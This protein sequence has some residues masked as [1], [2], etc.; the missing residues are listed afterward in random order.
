VVPVKTVNVRFFVIGSDEVIDASGHAVQDPNYWF[1]HAPPDATKTAFGITFGSLAPLRKHLLGANNVWRQC[2]IRFRWL[3]ENGSEI[4]YSTEASLASGV[5]ALGAVRPFVPLVSSSADFS[6]EGIA[7]DLVAQDLTKNVRD[8]IVSIAPYQD[9]AGEVHIFY[10]FRQ[11][12]NPGDAIVDPEM[13][14]GVTLDAHVF[15]ASPTVLAEMK[16]TPAGSPPGTAQLADVVPIQVLAHE[17]GHALGLGPV[18]AYSTGGSHHSGDRRSLM[19]FSF[20][21]D[22]RGNFDLGIGP[23]SSTTTPASE[24]TFARAGLGP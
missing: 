9:Q 20:Q 1:N 13:T 18:F 12:G 3:A 6:T 2:G 16:K 24:C 7:P 14:L 23:G 11:Y 22:L 4:D 17:T 21:D 10:A 19:Y 5:A 8:K 15:L